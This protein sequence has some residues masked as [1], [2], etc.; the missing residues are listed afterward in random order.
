GHTPGEHKTRR[1]G[2]EYYKRDGSGSKGY[3][4]AAR[5]HDGLHW[6]IKRNGQG[7]ILFPARVRSVV[8]IYVH[9]SGGPVRIVHPS[10]DDPSDAAAVIT[11]WYFQFDGDGTDG[12]YL[13]GARPVADVRRR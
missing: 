1:F 10:G 7:R 8:R 4:P 11:V 6:P 2:G 13:F 5:L 9:R 3:E 12:E